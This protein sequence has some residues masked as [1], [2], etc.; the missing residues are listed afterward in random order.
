MDRKDATTPPL[1]GYS[2]P[3]LGGSIWREEPFLTEG[4]CCRLLADIAFVLVGLSVMLVKVAA[5]AR[6]MERTLPGKIPRMNV[7]ETVSSSA[8]VSEPFNRGT[9]CTGASSAGLP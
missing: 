5:P 6:A 9:N 8:M 3:S 1:K 7:A 4:Y 2:R